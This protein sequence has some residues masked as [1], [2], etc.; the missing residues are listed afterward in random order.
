MS[1]VTATFSIS[2]PPEMA[3]ELTRLQKAE[4]R[5]RSELVREALRAYIRLAERRAMS[6]RIA[7]LPEEEASEDERHAVA[8]GAADFRKGR[9]ATL[10]ALRHD[11]RRPSRP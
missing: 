1:R 4:H 8:E 7:A 2:L 5:T 9:H 6:E 10:D 11:L 3:E